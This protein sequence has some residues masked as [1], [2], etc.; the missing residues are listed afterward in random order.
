MLGN[1]DY[2]QS[3]GP[4]ALEVVQSKANLGSI[5]AVLGLG[6][7][8]QLHDLRIQLRHQNLDGLV[9]LGVD[10]AREDPI[11]GVEGVEVPAVAERCRKPRLA[12]Y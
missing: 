11:Q 4:E 7:G 1:L 2:N 3:K 12:C 5:G 10:A 6:L 9:R 8:E